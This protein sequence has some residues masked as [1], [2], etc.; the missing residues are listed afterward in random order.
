MKSGMARARASV[1]TREGLNLKYVVL[2]VVAAFLLAFVLSGVI[3]LVI[4]Q[5][6]LSEIHSPLVMN[7][8]SF[9]CLFLGGVYAG[10]RA[11]TAGWAHGALTGAVYLVLVSILGLLLFDQLA[12][13]LILLQRVVLGVLIGA[14]GGTVGINLRHR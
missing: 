9:L 4:Y 13:W 6:W 3:G 14:V 5:G 12:P 1:R 2:G 7:I 11:G 8:V 10:T